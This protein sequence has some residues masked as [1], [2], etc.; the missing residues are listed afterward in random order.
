MKWISV[1]AFVGIACFAASLAWKVAFFSL[2]H[3]RSGQGSLDALPASREQL[4]AFD[5]M[6]GYTT[7]PALV[8]SILYPILLAL[9]GL[10][11]RVPSLALPTFLVLAGACGY[12]FHGGS[13]AEFGQAVGFILMGAVYWFSQRE[14]GLW[15]AFWLVALSHFVWN[16]TAVLL[17]AIT[18]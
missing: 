3:G 18:G 14:L 16:S 10:L 12:I 8:E 11:G 15:A 9:V 5:V 4:S 7:I 6:L 17:W 2:F 13:P 1:S